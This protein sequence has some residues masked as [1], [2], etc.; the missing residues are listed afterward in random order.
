MSKNYILS[1]ITPKIGHL[2]HAWI[3]D[4]TWVDP[5]NLDVYMMIVDSSYRNYSKWQTIIDNK[6]LGA[7]TGMKR[8]SR[9]DKNGQRVMSADSFPQLVTPLDESM[10]IQ[11]IE[12][13]QKDLK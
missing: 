6:M 5:D 13:A 11:I 10:I 1:D 3:W 2:N 4:L 8:S 7:Y 12:L 9:E